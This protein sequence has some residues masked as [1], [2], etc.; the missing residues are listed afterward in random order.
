MIGSRGIVHRILALVLLAIIAILAWFA[1][2]EPVLGLYAQ[3]RDEVA[4]AQR[5]L[6]RYEAIANYRQRVADFV[7]ETREQ[8]DAAAFLSGDSEQ[9]AVANLQSHLKSIATSSGASFRSASSL[10]LRTDS[11]L[12][13]AGV[14]IALSGPLPSIHKTIHQIETGK[15]YLFVERAQLQP[16]RQPSN[17]PD[18]RKPVQLNAQLHVYGVLDTPA[19]QE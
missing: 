3:K 16:N 19:E 11:Q 8:H 13:L 12:Q 5:L 1:A 14:Q 9:I 6:M 10:P 4:E 18:N 17:N 2:V 15:P 7:A